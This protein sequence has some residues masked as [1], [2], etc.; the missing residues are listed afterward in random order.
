MSKT[1]DVQLSQIHFP[2]TCVVCMSRA[3][4]HYKLD[5]IFTYGRRSYTVTVDVPM[6]DQHFNAASFK[7]TAE[8]LV[9]TLGVILGILVG[10][11]AMIVLILR[12]QGTGEGN[13]LLNLFVGGVFGLGMFLIVWA[14]ISLS[15]APRFAD[16]ASKEARE[17]VRITQYWPKDQFVQLSFEN[18]PLA[19]IVQRSS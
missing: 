18:E 14:V 17:A 9:G 15:I 5:K 19:D 2:M 11:F 3:I 10:L 7:G 12:W 4:K 16:P 6:C 8:R 1:I 13:I